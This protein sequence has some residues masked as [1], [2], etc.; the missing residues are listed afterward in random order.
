MKRIQGPTGMSLVVALALAGS[1]VFQACGDGDE[2]KVDARTDAPGVRI[3]AG[4]DGAVDRVSDQKPGVDTGVVVTDGAVA[5]VKI[6]ED[7]VVT[8]LD[9]NAD[10]AVPPA[11]APVQLDVDNPV[12]AVVPPAEVGPVVDS[13]LADLP[14]ADAPLTDD[15]PVT[16]ADGGASDS[17]AGPDSPLTLDGAAPDAAIIDA[18]AIDSTTIDTAPVEAAAP[19]AITG[20][21]TATFDFGSQACGG[22][23]PAARTFTLTN[24]SGMPVTLTSAKFTGT[25]GYSS[26]AEGKTIAAG[27]NLVVTIHAPGIPQ[28]SAIPSHYDD[29]LTIQTNIANDDQHLVHVTESAKG[30]VLVWNTVA[31]FGSFDPL[32]PGHSSTDN[33]QVVNNGNLPANV[34][35]A[36]TGP[37]A[38]TPVTTT[39]AAGQAADGVLTFTAPNAGGAVVGKLS[40]SLTS[41]VALCQPLPAVLG[42]TGTSENGAIS[43]SAESLSFNTACGATP[44]AKTLTIT[45]TG[46]AAMT[47]AAVLEAE[48]PVFQ[49]S[50]TGATLP[51]VTGTPEPSSVVTVTPPTATTSAVVSDVIDIATDAIGDAVH[52]VVL[53]QTPLGDV[54]EV[55]VGSTIDLGSV[56]ISASNLSSPP[57][58]FTVRNGANTN[59]APAVVSFQMN[60]TDKDYFTVTPAQL[61]IPAGGQGSVSITFSPGS[62]AA[63]VT[64]GNHIDLSATLH[65]QVGSEPNCGPASG[66][67]TINGTAILAQIAGIPGHLE[68]NLVNCGATAPPQQITI[69]NPGSATSQVTDIALVNSTYYA[70]DYP[71]LPK[72]LPPGGSMVV[73]VTPNGI[74]ATVTAV[75]DHARYDG[76]LTITTDVVGDSPH[77]VGLRMGAQGAIIT[78]ALWPT[79]WNF[80]TAPLSEVRNLNVAVKNTGNV[81]VTATLDDII[82][83]SQDPIFN[84]HNDQP[85]LPAGQTSNIVVE[86]HPT[87]AGV[88]YTA[89]A[90][91]LLSVPT[92]TVFCQPLPEGWNNTSH[93]VHMQGTSVSN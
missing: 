31:D 28:V 63:I 87:Q 43:L 16:I 61:T 21:P 10:Q 26:D 54:I 90:N 33:F 13:A 2:H 42:L 7:V 77:Q 34:A 8:L 15:G 40:V 84:L 1:S 29:I 3:D 93:N 79:E 80:G 82:I 46:A 76:Q 20:W 27:A 71:T 36:T 14:S 37:F 88:T 5:D 45:N 53:T 44:A 68:F 4:I 23:A 65:W 51:A 22:E 30:A 67:I 57:I 52:K 32:A 41:P 17:P 9:T 24:T 19:G 73:T 62:N 59:S 70:V 50:P 78:N 64:S 81:P 58:T 11:D 56:P 75:P 85:V 18:P 72:T 74:P 38:A 69:T 25:Y 92:N 39:I 83:A 48:H 86:F 66:D 91:L 47:W 60:G 55:R 6:G 89:T 35:L 49:I 12:D